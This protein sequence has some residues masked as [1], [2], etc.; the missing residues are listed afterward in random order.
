[1]NKLISSLIILGII[2]AQ[3]PG[4]VNEDYN[5]NIQDVIIIV[6][7]IIDDSETNYIADINN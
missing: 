1:M 7:G 4:D 2:Y 3:C 5:I 6:N